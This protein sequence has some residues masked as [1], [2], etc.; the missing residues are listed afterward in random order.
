MT[1]PYGFDARPANAA[2]PYGF[3]VTPTAP[4]ASP[5]DGPVN[6]QGGIDF[7]AIQA[8]E[9]ASEAAG[10][11]TDAAGVRQAEL[12]A[13]Q[14]VG[15]TAGDQFFRG[16]FDA[17]LSPG[18]LAGAAAESVGSAL[19]LETL[20]DFGRDLGRAATGTAAAEL[21]SELAGN[22]VG[23]VTLDLSEQEEA[24]PLLA[25]IARGSGMVAT[26][27][28]AGSTVTKA[29]G[30]L[31]AVGTG[32]IEG[33]GAGAQAGYEQNAALQDVLASTAIGGLFGAAVPAGVIG[34]QKGFQV[35]RKLI[36]KRLSGSLRDAIGEFAESRATKSALGNNQKLYNIIT[37]HGNNPEN[38]QRLGRKLLDADAPVAASLDN[39]SAWLQGRVAR[40]DGIRSQIASAADAA[41]AKV[42]AES[43]LTAVRGQVDELRKVG[44][45]SHDAI[46]ARVENEMAP[47]AKAVIEGREYSFGEWWKL[48][49]RF[50][51]TINWAKKGQDPATE[52]LKALRKTIDTGL[53]DAL[54]ARGGADDLALKWKQAGRDSHDW[55][56]LLDG[57]DE[58][59]LRKE[60]NRFISPSDYGSG[61]VLAMITSGSLGALPGVALGAGASLAHKVIRERGSGIMAA[62]ANRLART[63]K[64]AVS[65]AKVGG[66]EAQDAI[67]QLVQVRTFMRE[68][69]ESV[70]DNPNVRRNAEDL[71]KDA[72]GARFNE[73]IG[74]FDPAKWSARSPTPTPMQKV[75][76][77]SQILD[78]ASKDMATAAELAQTMRPALP[79][80]LDVAKLN[81]LLKDADRPAAIGAIQNKL[82]ELADAAPPTP[83][84]AELA[85][86]FRR[87]ADKLETVE[88]AEA[89]QIGHAVRSEIARA[90]QIDD[91]MGFRAP[92]D[93]AGFDSA[94][95]DQ[96]FGDRASSQLREVLGSETFGEAG[97]LYRS[98]TNVSDAHLKLSDPAAIRDA[99]RVADSRG[100]LPSA[101]HDANESILAAAEARAK[102]TGEK[103]PA[104][105]A[106]EL[107]RSEELFAAGE[108][109]ATL[110]GRRISRIFEHIDEAPKGP[111]PQRAVWDAVAP[112][113]D[114][115]V[116]VI[117]SVAGESKRGRYRPGLSRAGASE[118][119]ERTF[120]LPEEQRVEY[121]RQMN[122]VADVLGD[123]SQLE[124]IGVEPAIAP[125]VGQKLAQFMADVPKPRRDI[126]GKAFETM[127]SDDLRMARAM[128]EATVRPLSVLS[129]F[130]AGIVDYDKVQYAWKQWPGLQV[131]VQ[132]GILD[133]IQ[134]DLDDDERAGLSDTMLTQ[135]DLLAGFGGRLQSSLDPAFSARIDTLNTSPEQAKP[136]SGGGALS[137]PKAEPTFT[138]RV[139]GAQT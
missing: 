52:N 60:K 85:Y 27:L 33:A 126:R 122:E 49:Q 110:D 96:A 24:R 95:Y 114:R 34:A 12:E 58:Q 16:V 19:G 67:Q 109:A 76:F 47:L 56:L 100:P 37:N 15:Q 68:A 124:Q 75:L 48:R 120:D 88:A 61:A 91:A 46:A 36:D 130:R 66:R 11:G 87:A 26:G 86:T 53:D 9:I 137:T 73:I 103:V 117:K 94:V 107:R 55:R 84:A 139:A 54:I 97:T 38:V 111:D 131:A 4:A 65:V 6:E 72:V 22:R 71:A 89:M 133:V 23:Q 138:E 10:D 129:D 132:A 35:G 82:I 135:L 118:G 40:A 92:G 112:E 119:T 127:S 105:L 123:P 31:A 64:P 41:G 98:A 1:Q 101:L 39:Q 80:S 17:I 43:V 81:K 5:D 70:G 74:D 121:D 106:Q 57:V 25:T 2:G 32:T 50:D 79:D 20:R 30:A 99:L 63:P 42:D 90:R 134:Q 59:I 128:Y 18:A 136:P 104:G 21:L 3:S 77:R 51:D 116:P 83:G 113:I 8:A 78:T 69:A 102:L 7:A 115:L 45:G 13:R 14:S 93:A 44:L 29:P 125:V 108:E 28:A 62:L